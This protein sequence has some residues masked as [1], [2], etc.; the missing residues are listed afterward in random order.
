MTSRLTDWWNGLSLTSKGQIVVSLPIAALLGSAVMI[1]VVLEQQRE[2]NAWLQRT[3]EAESAISNTTT[4]LLDAQT[5]IRSYQVTAER[6]LLEGYERAVVGLPVELARLRALVRD[7]PAQVER[8]E[9]VSAL[10]DVRMAVLANLNESITGPNAPISPALTA[11]LVTGR[12][13]TNALRAELTEMQ[14]VEQTLLQARAE[15]VQQMEDLLRITLAVSVV[16]GLIGGLVATRLYTF[17]IVRRVRSLEENSR[18]LVA[19]KPLLRLPQAADELGSLDRAF[20]VASGLLAEHADALLASQAFLN[21]VIESS[22]TMILGATSTSGDFALNYVSGN[23]KPILGLEPTEL[24]AAPQTWRDRLHPDDRL[25]FRLDVQAAIDHPEATVD[26]EYRVR[27]ARDDYRWLSTSLKSD[28]GPNGQTAIFAYTKDVTE[29]RAMRE[30]RRALRA[31]VERE[32]STLAAITESMSDG[33]LVLDPLGCVRYC[34]DR[35]AEL[36]QLTPVQAIGRSLGEIFAAEGLE[37]ADPQTTGLNWRAAIASVDARPQLEVTFLRP[38]RVE[39]LA[40]LF[41][42]RPP[43]SRESETG[44]ILRDIT[45]QRALARTK[46]E[47]VSVVSHELRTPLASLVGFAEL[48]LNRDYDQATRRRFLSIIHEEGLR[49]TALINDFLD[50]QRLESGRQAINLEPTDV[51]AVVERSVAAAGDDLLHPTVLEF[52]ERLPPF[53]ADADRIQ[54]VLGNLI[55]NARKYS[56]A[57]GAVRIRAGERQGMIAVSVTDQGLGVPAEAIPN[58]FDKFYRVDN[59]DRRAIKG[60]GLGLAICKQIVTAHGGQIWAESSGLGAGT[61]FS[62]TI[63]IADTGLSD[64]EVLIVEDDSGFA[65]LLEV[66]LAS[67]GLTATRT[68]SAEAA[69]GQIGVATPQAVVLDLLLPGLAGEDFLKRFR[70]VH[71]AAIPVV[72]VSVKDLGPRERGVLTNLGNVTILRKGPGTAAAAAEA[73]ASYLS[74][75]SESRPKEPAL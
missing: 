20:Q 35:S 26:N 68:P 7:N 28:A 15:R 64:G 52:P 57:G 61:T 17:S 12:E 75:P 44:I 14:R 22:P 71:G 9:R 65:R 53:N 1:A 4:M 39:I 72:V 42:V 67:L 41:P 50:L 36:L 31:V 5:S 16:V 3:L 19:G 24:L 2:A 25:S 11:E 34:N 59:S 37:I 48:L 6:T 56:P 69:F 51:Q 27:D 32:R 55:S 66:E 30:E 13:M 18:R 43:G 62:F 40:Q 8:A 73:I 10:M 46:D 58:L 63:P 54:Q 45:V 49:L 21:R 60:T 74:S 47:L 23:V 29:R 33:L 70:Q 38:R